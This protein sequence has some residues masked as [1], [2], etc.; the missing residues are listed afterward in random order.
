MLAVQKET[1]ALRS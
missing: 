1:S